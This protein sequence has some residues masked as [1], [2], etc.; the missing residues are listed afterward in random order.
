MKHSI[1]E[2]PQDWARLVGV[3]EGVGVRLVD[4]DVSVVS[5][6]A[7]K[8]LEVLAETPFLVDLEPH[9][10][11][12][13]DLDL[14]MFGYNG[15]L[16]RRH[17]KFVHTTLLALHPRAWGQANRGYVKWKSP[18]KH[19]AIDFRYEVIKVWKLP[20]DQLLQGGVGVLPIAPL[21]DVPAHGLPGVIDQIAKRYDREISRSVAAELWTATYVLLGLKFEDPLI[22]SLLRKVV[23]I[24]QE[25]TT[26]QAIIEQGI[27]QGL[28]QAKCDDLLLLAE[29]RFGKPSKAVVGRVR[30]IQTAAEL[31]R[32]LLRMLDVGSWRELLPPSSGSSGR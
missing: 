26:Y 14:R 24:M 3:R 27:E 29:K 12:D 15:L 32:L 22:H 10:Y 4:A 21:A 13:P 30:A 8:V 7:D 9:S 25:S 28:L 6:A 31:D 23:D 5:Q 1:T 18:L 11:Y 17:H 2:F 16:S 20:I 19:V